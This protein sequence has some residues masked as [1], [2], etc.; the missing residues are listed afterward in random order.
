[1]NNKFYF[2]SIRSNVD[3]FYV[4]SLLSKASNL[5]RK[6]KEIFHF[7]LGEPQIST[8]DPIIKEIKKL[9]R[10]N[11]WI[12]FLIWIVPKRFIPLRF[13]ISPNIIKKMYVK[14]IKI[15]NFF[16]PKINNKAASD[17]A[18]AFLDKV[19]KIE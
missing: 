12:K 18:K 15:R 1:M 13:K 19:K 7:E 16:N 10:L 2:P 14:D 8:P 3:S 4:M 6:G 17:P 5:E 9:L 11:F